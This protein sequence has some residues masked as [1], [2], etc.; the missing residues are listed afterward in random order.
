M[1]HK[2]IGPIARWVDDHLF[3]HVRCEFLNDL[4]MRHELIAKQISK[5]GSFSTKGGCTFFMGCTLPDR[6]TEEFDEDMRFPFRD[7]ISKF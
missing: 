1:R 3:L 4:N 6:T 2:G 7:L 5:L